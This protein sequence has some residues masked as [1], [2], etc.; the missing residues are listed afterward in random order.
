MKKLFSVFAIAIVFASCSK[1]KSPVPSAPKEKKFVER[2]NLNTPSDWTKYHYDASG[3]LVK[4]ETDSRFTTYQYQSS[5]VVISDFFQS[6]GQL[7]GKQDLILDAS[8]RCVSR[9]YIQPSGDTLMIDQIQYNA[10]G[11]L[12]KI[13]TQY[14][15]GEH[16]KSTYV[17]EGGNVVEDV[18]YRNGILNDSTRYYY[19]G[20][21]TKSGFNSITDSP[22][23]KLYG[24]RSKNVL[25]SFKRYDISGQLTY[26]RENVIEVD[27]DGYMTKCVAKNLTAGTTNTWTYKY[28]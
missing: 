23:G 2:N 9:Y 18:T 3:R 17:I 24:E 1:E 16:W 6:N 11:F 27:A 13:E 14:K 21:V 10:T 15:T 28:E 5:K 19:S 8:G 4:E 25:N 22:V 20:V 26:S 12:T 7:S